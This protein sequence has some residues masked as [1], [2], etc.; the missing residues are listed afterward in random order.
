MAT[1][2]PGQVYLT[3]ALTSVN[4]TT[5][6][7]AVDIGGAKKVVLVLQRTNHSS[8]NTVYTVTVSVDGTVYIPYNK[9]ITNVANTNGQQVT[10]VASY[11]S[12]SNESVLYTL[13]PMDCFQFVKV[14]ATITTDGRANAWVLAQY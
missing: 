9:L 11:T 3:K 2:G 6:S 12:S 10:R 4:S 13:D 8:G 14:T 5:I 1:N 7:D